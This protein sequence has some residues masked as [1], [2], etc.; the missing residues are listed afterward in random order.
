MVILVLYVV[1]CPNT[2]NL[3]CFALVSNIIRMTMLF[4]LIPGGPSLRPLLRT[5]FRMTAGMSGWKRRPT[6]EDGGS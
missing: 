1:K 2:F 6:R 3:C 4:C 5:P